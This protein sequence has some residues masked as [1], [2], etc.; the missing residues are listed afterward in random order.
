MSENLNPYACI[1]RTI[2]SC[3]NAKLTGGIHMLLVVY[4]IDDLTVLRYFKVHF[5]VHR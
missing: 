2:A 3:V 1:P 5:G 4:E